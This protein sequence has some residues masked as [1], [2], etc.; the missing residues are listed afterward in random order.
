M[1]AFSRIFF[2]TVATAFAFALVTACSSVK[3]VPE[4]KYLLDNTKITIDDKSGTN[5]NP[6]D[7]VNFLRQTENHKVLGGLKL[8]LA[9]YN[10]SGKDSTRWF[11]RW[12]Q[13]IGS[14]PVIYDSTLTDASVNQLHR[15]LSNK[16]YMNNT[17]KSVVNLNPEKRKAN[18]EY[19]V[20][21]GDP[22]YIRSINYNIY[23]DTLSD[24]VLRDTT[25]FPVHPGSLLD[26]KA[27]DHQRE[28]V[29]NILRNNG[30]YAFNKEYITFTADTAAGSLAVD[31]TMNLLPPR[32]NERMPYLDEHK[33][34]KIRN[35]TYV[36]G[37]DPVVMQERYFGNDTV[38]FNGLTIIQDEEYLHKSTLDDNC[39]LRPGE[40][41]R[42]FNV[43]KTYKA[44]SRLGI[45]KFINIE[46]QP[47]GEI[48][49]T[50]WLDA[51]ILLTRDKDQSVSLSLE[52]T[53]SEGDL[54]FGVGVDYQHRN[55]FKGSETLTA[56]F[57]TSYES[58]S[59]DL[60]GLINDN[61][62]E[63]AASIGIN[64]PKF[65]FPFLP[66]SFKRRVQAST[67][68]NTSFNYQRRPEYTRIIAGMGWKYIWSEQSN[69]VR[70]TFNLIDLNY[71]YLPK[72]KINFLDSITNPLLRYSYENH[73][74]M[75]TGYSFYKTN[76]ITNSSL[77]SIKQKNIYTWRASAETA[78]NFLYAMSKIFNQKREQDDSYKIF[79]IRYAQ[80]VKFD[81]DYSITHY[82]DTRNS[83]AFH[84]GAGVA[85]PY[86]NQSVVPFEKRFYAGGANSVRGWSVRT[87]GPGSFN[88]SNSQ[89][90]FIYQCGD[91]RFDMNL[92]YRAKLFWV[93][94]MGLF[95]DAGNIWT[96]KDYADQPGGVFKFDKFY[97]QIAL[98][99]GIGLRMDFTYFLMRL[100]MGMKAHNPATGQ[101]HWPLTSP[102]FK[103]DAVF[104]F[105]IGYPF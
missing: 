65:K 37:Y 10:M 48:D 86:G 67:E 8:Q 75:R 30:Y 68:F 80:Y 87:L 59:G 17:V 24:L 70:H 74:I 78:G 63:Y 71:V 51:F 52:G 88:A 6:S 105:S 96:I 46:L 97:E 94:E 98:S 57:R 69:Q 26:H 43:D 49:G 27:L 45:L 93:I 35:V 72:S 40:I 25:I 34:F 13:R 83:I 102:N 82:F 14:P 19:Q 21:L 95:I 16:G 56:K 89:N 60:S 36:T 100:D 23:N 28:L 101:E 38:E 42:A 76:K 11:N 85:I 92:E 64:F 4:G 90:S 5:I 104:H 22:Y 7:L 20:H 58:I 39:F 2:R 31:L 54:G 9:I 66:K 47:I 32:I 79:G 1:T 81:G 77:T 73:M 50:V 33:V 3:H 12:I 62:S 53:N 18:V 15:A 91:V 61:Y 84:V 41:F 55:I 103:R 99:Y 44:L 29:S